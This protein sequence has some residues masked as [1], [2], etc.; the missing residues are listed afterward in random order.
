MIFYGLRKENIQGFS[1]VEGDFYRY[2]LGNRVEITAM[3]KHHVNKVLFENLSSSVKEDKLM[4][5]YC[6]TNEILFKKDFI[7]SYNELDHASCFIDGNVYVGNKDEY[8]IST[9]ILAF[10][11]VLSLNDRIVSERTILCN[12]QMDDWVRNKVRVLACGV[13]DGNLF[14]LYYIRGERGLAVSCDESGLGVSAKSLAVNDYSDWK[15]FTLEDWFNGAR[16][17]EL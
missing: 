2:S 10:S 1:K 12:G 9:G 5:R 7:D 15:S 16:I 13:K 17:K 8:N 14:A 4:V 3:K 11:G 6:P